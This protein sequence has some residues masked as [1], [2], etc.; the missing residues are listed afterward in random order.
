[1]TI[2][3]P[4]TTRTHPIQA[5]LSMN[6][7]EYMGMNGWMEGWRD[8]GMDLRNTGLKVTNSHYYCYPICLWW[9]V[10]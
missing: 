3:R 1:V 4:E 8:W 2:K 6:S 7:G 9:K 5:W 10:K